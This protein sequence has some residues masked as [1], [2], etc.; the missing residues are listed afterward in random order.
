MN[1]TAR[2]VDTTND[3][4]PRPTRGVMHAALSRWSRDDDLFVDGVDVGRARTDTGA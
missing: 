4:T 3:A 1:N 2:R